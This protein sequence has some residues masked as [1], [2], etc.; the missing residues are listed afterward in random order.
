MLPPSATADVPVAL[1]LAPIAVALLPAR[2]AVAAAYVPV[3]IATYGLLAVAAEAIAEFSW[4]RLTAS[5]PAVPAA[6]PVMRWFVMLTLLLKSA[7]PMM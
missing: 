1:A 7:G 3:L 4:L 2:A 6:S 5:V